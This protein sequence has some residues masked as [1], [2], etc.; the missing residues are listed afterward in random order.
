V[1]SF[2]R[3]VIARTLAATGLLVVLSVVFFIV[4]DYLEHIDDFMDRGATWQSVA[5]DYYLNYIPEIIRLTSPLAIFLGVIFVVSR[6]AQTLQIVALRS[7]GVSLLRLVRP[8]ATIGAALTVVMFVFNGWVVP[9]TQADVLEFQQRY[10]RKAQ[11]PIESGQIYRQTAPGS[12][13]A[14]GFYDR[15]DTRA[16]RVS[17]QDFEEDEDRQVPRRIVRR[18]DAAEM[19]WVDSLNLWRLRDIQVRTFGGDAA[20]RRQSTLDTTLAILPRDLARTQ[21]DAERLT[22]TEARDY[23][24]SLRRAGADR[25]GR[26]LVAYYS[27]FTYPLANLIV[28]LIAVPLASVRRRGGQAVPIALGLLLAFAYLSVQK[29]TEPFGYTETLAPLFVAWLPH[30]IFLGVAVGVL[31]YSRK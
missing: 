26:P 13:L 23:I 2:D 1:N 3:H 21:A 31:F 24:R 7:A 17:L 16:F 15:R 19:V 18:V 8:F 27:K 6:M 20:T 5:F 25:L 10:L 14:V 22:I 28:V 11:E 12:V 4:L 9:H 29:L 30:V